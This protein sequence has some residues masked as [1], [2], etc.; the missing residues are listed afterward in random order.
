KHQTA[1]AGKQVDLAKKQDFIIQ[2][3]L[4]RRAKLRIVAEDAAFYIENT[5]NKSIKGVSWALLLPVEWIGGT[6]CQVQDDRQIH[7]ARKGMVVQ[8]GKNHFLYQETREAPIYPMARDLSKICEVL[9][10]S[11]RLPASHRVLWRIACDDGLFPE[12]EEYGICEAAS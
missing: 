10:A 11:D 2:S 3:Q 1:L 6:V 12:G 4:A 5:G 9:G 7:L 8:D